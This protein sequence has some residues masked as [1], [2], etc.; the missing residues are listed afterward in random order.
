MSGHFLTG[1][2]HSL[3][4]SLPCRSQKLSMSLALLHVFAAHPFAA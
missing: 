1:T 4:L 2:V 3:D